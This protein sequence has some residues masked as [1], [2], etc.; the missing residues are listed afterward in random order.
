VISN[1]LFLQIWG[2][3]CYLLAKILLAVSEGISNGRKWRIVGWFSYLAGV[4]AWVIILADNSD[5]VIA[6]NDLG[7]IPSMVMGI[8]IA[9]KKDRKINKIFDKFVQYFTFLMIAAGIIY[10]IYCFHGITKFTQILEILVIIGFL[11]G[12]YLLAKNIPN[13]WL[14]FILMCSSIIILMIVQDKM[15]LAFLQGISL[16]VVIIGYIKAIRKKN[17]II[18]AYSPISS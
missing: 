1:D 7:S 14:F 10:S 17:K 8:I 3:T 6:S 18:R 9:W 4:P 15:L 13:G 12:S 16:I 11:A 2:G 5:W